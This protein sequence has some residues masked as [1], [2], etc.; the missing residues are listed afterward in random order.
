MTASRQVG[1]ASFLAVILGCIVATATSMLGVT[2]AWFLDAEAHL[3]G[4]LLM[5][6]FISLPIIAAID[7]LIK[8]RGGQTGT[9]SA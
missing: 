2:I 9:T 5:L 8:H 1:L 7:G 6:A 3:R 4:L